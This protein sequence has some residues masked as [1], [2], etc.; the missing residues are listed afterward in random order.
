MHTFC[1]KYNNYIVLLLLTF[2]QT[3]FAHNGSIQ[4]NISQQSN[5]QPVSDALIYV[6]EL[7]TTTFTNT[8]GNYTIIRFTQRNLPSV[9][10]A[11]WF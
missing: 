5:G 8:F 7:S 6:T 11:Y 10:C 1:K 9:N 4:G 3:V 2:S